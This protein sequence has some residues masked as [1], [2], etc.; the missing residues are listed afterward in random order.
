MVKPPRR[1]HKRPRP[2]RLHDVRVLAPQPREL[3]AALLY[4]LRQPLV[5]YL[6][7]LKVDQVQALGELLAAAQ[8]RLELFEAAGG[9]VLRACTV[10]GCDVRMGAQAEPWPWAR[11]QSLWRLR[12]SSP[13]PPVGQVH[14]FEPRPLERL[15]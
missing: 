3:L 15:L 5:L 8:G 9:G 1:P 10:G 12:C 7:L 6:E 4:L 11:G 2:A 13:S 14:V